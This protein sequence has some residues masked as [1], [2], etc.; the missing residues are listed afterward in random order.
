[1]SQKRAPGEGSY[2]HLD[3]AVVACLQGRAEVEP[4]VK[5][6]LG[7]HGPDQIKAVFL[8]EGER[9][10]RFNRARFT[11]LVESLRLRGV[12]W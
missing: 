3:A 1:M 11:E 9:Y 5:A 10:R 4:S 8:D 12:L 7:S 2:Q 6:I